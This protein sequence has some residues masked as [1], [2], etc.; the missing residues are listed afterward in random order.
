[1][2]YGKYQEVIEYIQSSLNAD[3]FAHTCR[4][5]NYALQILDAEK[6]ADA[7]VVIFAAIL[8]DIGRADEEAEDHGK[9]GSEKSYAYLTEKGYADELAK[10]VANCILTHCSCSEVPPQTLEAKILFDADK[11]DTTGAVGTARA[12]AQCRLEGNPMYALGEDGLPLSGKKEEASSLM[13]KYSRKLK[14]LEKVF[15]TEKAKKIAVK[16]QPIMDEYFNQLAEELE[17]N[18]KKGSELIK[19]YCN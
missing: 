3:D 11:L 7:S 2:N 18:Y 19:K 17:S 12:I 9:A 16:R 13:K 4:V 10:S 1:M 5:F 6:K 14:K 15:F 8:H